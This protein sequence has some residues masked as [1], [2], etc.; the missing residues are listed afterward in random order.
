M[1][2]VRRA[3][4]RRHVR[5]HD[6]EGWLTFYPQNRVKPLI[7]G[8]GLLESFTE[9][10]L[11]PGAG[12]PVHPRHDAEIVTYVWAGSLAHEDAAGRSAILHAGEF[13]RMSA[14]H[15]MRHSETNASRTDWAHIFQMWLHPMTP[16]L[17]PSQEQ[18]RFCAADRRGGLCVVASPDGRNGSLRIHQDAVIH[19]AMLDPGQ[20]LVHEL[21]PGRS[22]WLHIVRGEVTIDDVVLSTGDGAGMTMARAVSLTAQVETEI[23]LLDLD[24][25]SQR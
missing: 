23:L 6:G 15:R 20:H 19:S 8:F 3:K 11:P 17:E 21:S 9:D 5:R 7:G 24:G 16:G 18:K 4:E 10:R 1:I 2:I 12:V 25:R 22:A 14:G 13:Q